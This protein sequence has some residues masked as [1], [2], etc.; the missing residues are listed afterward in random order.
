MNT[1]LTES[2]SPATAAAETRNQY[3]RGRILGVWALAT[4][5]MGIFSWIVFPAW[6][7]NFS[8]DPLGAGVTRLVLILIGLIWLFVLSMIVVRQEEGDLRGGRSSA[9][10]VSTRRAIRKPVNLAAGY[11][12]G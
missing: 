4:I 6:S 12:C 10:F 7:P 5:P 1:L 3:S 2:N 8:L 11:G 9:G